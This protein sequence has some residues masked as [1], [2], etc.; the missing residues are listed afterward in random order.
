[1]L[2]IVPPFVITAPQVDD[3]L[4]RLRATLAEFAAIP[5]ETK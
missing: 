1:V 3:A 5:V 4:Q 2:R